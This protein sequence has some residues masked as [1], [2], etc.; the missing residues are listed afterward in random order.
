MN[1]KWC[2][3]KVPQYS[4]PVPRVSCSWLVLL[5]PDLQASLFQGSMPSRLHTSTSA[6]T[7]SL[8][9]F[10]G[11]H[12]HLGPGMAIPIIEFVQEDARAT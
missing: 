12:T 9:D 10:L 1:V 3:S 11:L 2:V 4:F 7:H 6:L 8:Q 5:T